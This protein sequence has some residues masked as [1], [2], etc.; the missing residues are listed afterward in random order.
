[1]PNAKLAFGLASLIISAVIL[2][3]AVVFQ[4][5]LEDRIWVNVLVIFGGVWGGLYSAPMLPGA[6]ADMWS[7]IASAARYRAEARNYNEL[8]A[9]QEGQGEA[10][11][12]EPTPKATTIYSEAWRLYWIEF[13]GYAKDCGGITYDKTAAFF[14]GNRTSG[15][16]TWREVIAPFIRDGIVTAVVERKTTNFLP[17]FSIDVVLALLNSGRGIEAKYI[18]PYPPPTPFEGKQTDSRTSTKQAETS[19]NSGK[20]DTVFAKDV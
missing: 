4:P 20:A 10:A 6:Y 12:G 5:A 14:G 9:R 1:M 15:L 11:Q 2:F 13:F 8:R 3:V 19:D 16:E 18:P 17:G 7:A